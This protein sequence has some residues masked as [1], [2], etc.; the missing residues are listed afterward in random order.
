L[1]KWTIES[2]IEREKGSLRS[3][4]AICMNIFTGLPKEKQQRVI[5]WRQEGGTNWSYTPEKFLE[6]MGSK[7]LDREEER[8][9]LDKL[10]RLRQGDKQK[11]EDF[12]QQ[13]EQLSAQAGSLSYRGPSKIAIIRRSLNP[14]L[15]RTLIPVELS[16][17]DYDAYVTKVQTIS[18]NFE[19][20]VDF[21]KQ[22]G[23]T[24]HYYVNE[25]SHMA[26]NTDAEGDVE[27][28]GV[29]ALSVQIAALVARVDALS[30]KKEDKRPRAK[31]RPQAEFSALIQ[32][33]KCGRCK[34]PKH[35][36]NICEFRPAA[37]PRAQVTAIATQPAENDSHEASS[38]SEY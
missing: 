28:T 9:A 31:W 26:N 17:T 33:G 24:T 38:G 34:Q 23:S 15:A 7:F 1:F 22:N 12:R 13:F 21:R 32:A 5:Y 29:N 36:P 37:R 4:K 2:K 27:M 8:K 25:G 18:T 35:N 19:A 30:D 10:D 16:N 3:N 6:H 20:H 14:S 11:F